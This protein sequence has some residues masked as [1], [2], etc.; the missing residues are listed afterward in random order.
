MFQFFKKHFGYNEILGHNFIPICIFTDPIGH[1]K[2]QMLIVRS[3]D[4]NLS[5]LCLTFEKSLSVLS[6][7]F[8][9]QFSMIYFTD[10]SYFQ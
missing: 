3:R 9:F 10:N 4:V 1:R 8:M 5:V 2:F 7:V 6:V